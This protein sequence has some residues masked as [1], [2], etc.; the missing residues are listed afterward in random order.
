M[1]TIHRAGEA[2]VD[3]QRREGAT[4]LPGACARL[5]AGVALAAALATTLTAGSAGAEER[6]PTSETS[7]GIFYQPDAPALTDLWRPG[8]PGEPLALRGRVLDV[9]GVPIADAQVEMWHADGA[10]QVHADRYRT[11]IKTG[12]DGSFGVR[13]AYPGHIPGAPGVWGARHIHIVVTHPGH[14]RLI[15]LIL[16]KGDEMLPGDQP[17]DLAIFAEQ[18]RVDGESMRFAR[19]EIVLERE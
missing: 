15:S 8:E 2:A 4:H 3:R 10:G 5:R 12:P 13:T 11:R 7:I 1:G 9:E 14:Q 6:A 19:V 17:A 18:G 16:F